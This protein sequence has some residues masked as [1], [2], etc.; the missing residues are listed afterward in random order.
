MTLKYIVLA[1]SWEHKSACP[2]MMNFFA[3]M[4][5]FPP[6]SHIQFT[7]TDMDSQQSIASFIPAL[8]VYMYASLQGCFSN[9]SVSICH[10]VSQ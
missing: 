9:L 4:S 1:M 5:Y 10:T 2:T 6:R 3:L 8:P 7:S